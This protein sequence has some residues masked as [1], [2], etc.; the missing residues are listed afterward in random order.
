ME[1]AL[2]SSLMAGRFFIFSNTVIAIQSIH[3]VILH[4]LSLAVVMGTG[5]ISLGA[6]GGNGRSRRLHG[7]HDRRERAAQ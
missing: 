4:P 2:G 5:L 1:R 7:R 6:G 3:R